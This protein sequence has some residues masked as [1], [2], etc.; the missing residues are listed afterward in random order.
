MAN[1]VVAVD[2]D[3]RSIRLLEI[4]EGRVE[5]WISAAIEPDTMRDGAVADPEAL[6]AQI[7]QLVRSSGVRTRQVVASLSGLY[8]TS[9]VLALHLQTERE[10]LRAVPELA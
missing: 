5:R 4:S 2:V 8:S 7:R 3:G 1:Q 9:Q 6:G 10:A